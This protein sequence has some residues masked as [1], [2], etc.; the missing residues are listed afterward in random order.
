MDDDD[1]VDQTEGRGKNVRKY[2][3]ESD[4]GMEDDDENY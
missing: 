3:D 2:T 4:I 1:Y